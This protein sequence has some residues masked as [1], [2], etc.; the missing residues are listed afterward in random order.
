MR[1]RR[2]RI[3]DARC[4]ALTDRLRAILALEAHRILDNPRVTRFGDRRKR[5]DCTPL[6]S[7]LRSTYA[8]D[9]R[10]DTSSESSPEAP[11]R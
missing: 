1:L 11:T 2:R 9:Q 3:G 8:S 10:V 4:R 5:I 6:Y 7:L